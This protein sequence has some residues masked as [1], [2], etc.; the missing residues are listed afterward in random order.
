MLVTILQLS[1]DHIRGITEEHRAI[2]W[3][4]HSLW[5]G[6]MLVR[7]SGLL[8]ACRQGGSDPELS[9][10]RREDGGRVASLDTTSMG[11]PALLQGDEVPCSRRDP[12][13]SL[14]LRLLPVL[15]LNKTHLLP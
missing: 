14:L 15:F 6:G 13:T 3:Q 7:G 8:P 12:T 2:P 1:K 10:P 9:F 4:A 11:S 5:P